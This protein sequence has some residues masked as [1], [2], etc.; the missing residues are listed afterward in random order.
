VRAALPAAGEARHDWRIA[1]DVAQRLEARLRPGPPSLFNYPTPE[2]IWLEHRD[3][4]RGRDLD[5]TGLSY[6]TL[7]QRGPQQWPLPEGS[8]HGRA[9]L[10]ENGIFP[11]ADGRA[12]F[13]ALPWR[14]L[15]EPRKSRFP[16]SLTTGRLRDHWHG[17]TRT[18]TLG[19]LFGHVAEPAVQLNPQDMARRGLKDGDLVHVTSKRGAIVLP[20]QGDAGIGL[21]QA[22]I[23]MHWGP[24]YLSGRSSV[25]EP[26]AGINAITTSAYCPSSKQP[27]LKHAAVKVLKADLP[28]TLLAVA[29]LPEDQALTV[30]NALRQLMPAFEFASCVPFGRERTG[31]LLRAAAHDAPDAALIDG[32]EQLL[33]L[34]AP[35]VLRYNDRRLGQRR[36]ARLLRQGEATTLEGFV[37]AGDCRA[38]AWILPLLQDELPADGY[39]RLLLMPGSRAPLSVVAK[40]RQ[41][42]TCFNVAEPAITEQLKRSEGSE[43]Q[44]LASLQ[45]GLQCGTNCGSCVPELRRLVRATPA[46][47]AVAI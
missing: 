26:L 38:E 2:S 32:I 4:T 24:E 40:G 44:R 13:A 30:L 25:G 33:G 42:C 34:A 36:S 14:P 41:V 28:W 1:V 23:A 31:V 17:M 7:E 16:F 21:S 22:F 19:R 9:R 11:T 15:A 5:I 39:G 27:E 45:S 46:A 37:L 18:G 20:A 8:A 10:Y 43:D 12:R 3:S 6:A 29:W 47:A 35:D